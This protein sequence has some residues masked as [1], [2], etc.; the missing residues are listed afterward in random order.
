M[1]PEEILICF[2]FVNHEIELKRSEEIFQITLYSGKLKEFDKGHRMQNRAHILIGHNQFVQKLRGTIQEQPNKLN[3]SD[4]N[5]FRF[6]YGLRLFLKQYTKSFES[7]ELEAGTTQNTQKYN[8]N[9][10]MFIN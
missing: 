9:C 3:L 4:R 10:L 5:R 7:L 8:E 1:I 6:H 2:S